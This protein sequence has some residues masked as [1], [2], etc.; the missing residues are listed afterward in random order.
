MSRIVHLALKVAD[1]ERT[2][3]FYRKVFRF[4]EVK[5]ER[6][7]DHTSRHLTDGA[8]DLSLM[9]YDAG[10]QSAESKAAGEG[11]CIHHFAVEVEDLEQAARA[12]EAYGG[13]IISDAGVIPMKFRAP[14]G[15]IVEIVPPGRY[16]KRDG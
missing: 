14:G 8:I 6:V 5:T 9:Q 16:E 3:E 12:I 11:P 2:T 7:R 10:T 4:T 13:Q 1:L 15:T